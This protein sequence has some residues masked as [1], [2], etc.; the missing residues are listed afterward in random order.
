MRTRRRRWNRAWHTA[1]S[2][3]SLPD[4]LITF[5][6][7]NLSPTVLQATWIKQPQPEAL[8]AIKYLLFTSKQGPSDCLSSGDDLV[9]W[10]IHEVRMHFLTFVQPGINL[11]GILSLLP[12]G[13]PAEQL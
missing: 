2:F 11:V 12:V 5:R 4:E 13:I 10:Y 9:D 1:T 8:E 3:L 7:A 6:T